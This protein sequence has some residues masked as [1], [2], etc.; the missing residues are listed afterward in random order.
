MPQYSFKFIT[1]IICFIASCGFLFYVLSKAPS[2]APVS[3]KTTPTQVPPIPVKPPLKD[4][5]VAKEGDTFSSLLNTLPIPS[6][7]A[8]EATEALSRVFNPTD[9]KV[10]QELHVVCHPKAESKDYDLTSLSLRPDIDYEI[11]L[12][13]TPTGQLEAKKHT[14]PLKHDYVD[15][16][17]NIRM[18]L[19]ADALR[20][21][22]SP[23][24]LYD[25]I[26]GFSYDVDFQRDTHPG[27]AFSL[28]YDTYKDEKTN[29]ERPGDL[30]YAKLVIGDTPH[31]IYYFQPS[32]GVAGYYTAKGS[33]IK[34]ALLRTP[35][36][37]ARLSSG[38]GN[39]KH[40]VLGYTKMHKG[41]DFAAP[42]GT[43]IMAAGDGVV[44]RRGP[45]SSYGNYICIRHGG[46][47][48]TA[49]AHLSRYAKN[50]KA[51][52]KVRQGQII[53]YVGRTGRATGNHLHFEL[54]QNGKHI[55]PQKITQLPK[56]A[57]TGKTLTAF[58]RF[59]AKIDKMRQD[60]EKKK[61]AL[62]RSH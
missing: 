40:P 5:L 6:S 49:Y 8:Q 18:S 28:F 62:R 56:T 61:R 44:E 10:D 53:G 19:Y 3:S 47:M 42:Q 30:L 24:M 45:Y 60:Q 16:G 59:K 36:D 46:N 38:F 37:G 39:R 21:G 29:L 11:K 51:G 9:L 14:I 55:N 13:R 15:I 23:K 20:M 7:H 4:T 35:I 48:K 25:M 52:C 58:K 17:G 33:N 31:E 54:L 2:H 50:I 26:K 43:P 41:V 32:G 57:L 1:T 12:E 22:A 34:T 27:T